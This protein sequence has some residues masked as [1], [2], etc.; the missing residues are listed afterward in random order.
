MLLKHKHLYTV[1]GSPAQLKISK[2]HQ[3]PRKKQIKSSTV[4][5]LVKCSN[6]QGRFVLLA[7]GTFY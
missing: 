3:N 2:A 1:V 4:I 6:I 7:L 5:N